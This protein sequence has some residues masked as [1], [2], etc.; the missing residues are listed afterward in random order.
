[1]NIVT[2]RLTSLKSFNFNF[3]DI[4]R[5]HDIHRER[6]TWNLFVHVFNF[7]LV[8]SNIMRFICS[9][10]GCACNSNRQLTRFAFRVYCKDFTCGFWTKPSF[11]LGW[12]YNLNCTLF[13]NLYCCYNLRQKMDKRI[14]N[15]LI[16]YV[17]VVQIKLQ[18][19]FVFLFFKKSCIKKN[20]CTGK[21]LVLR[22]S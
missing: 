10:K 6:R 12:G 7:H 4:N 5:F 17:C 11:F 16:Q 8:C 18:H 20:F 9:F 14:C 3:G 22:L 15:Q 19:F 2:G 1:M 13:S 21:T